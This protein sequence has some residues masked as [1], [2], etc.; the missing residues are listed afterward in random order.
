MG[1]EEFDMDAVD[2]RMNII[3]RLNDMTIF[4][5][6]EDTLGTGREGDVGDASLFPP[7]KSR[8]HRTATRQQQ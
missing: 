4:K 5:F 8:Q 6:F 2:V 3:S 1:E 7:D